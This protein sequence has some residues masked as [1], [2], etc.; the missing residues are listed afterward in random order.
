M[1]RRMRPISAMLIGVTST[2]ACHEPT[3]P[4]SASLNVD[5]DQ[6]AVTAF[7]SLG[8]GL[9]RVDASLTNTGTSTIVIFPCG[10]TVE[11]EAQPGRWEMLPEPYCALAGTDAV[12]LAPGAVISRS[13]TIAATDGTSFNPSGTVAGRYRLIYRYGAAGSAGPAAEARSD[14]FDVAE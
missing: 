2:L 1:K 10:P 3:R 14:T 4:V 11:R 5:V 9:F 6:S 13:E 7:R 12:E 8:L